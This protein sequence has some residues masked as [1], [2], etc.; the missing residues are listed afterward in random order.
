MGADDGHHTGNVRCRV[1]VS[2]RVQGVFFRDTCR[3][4]ADRLGLCG[5]V[6][7]RRDGTV[8]AV[9]EGDRNDVGELVAWCRE[10]PARAIVTDLQIVDEPVA[11]EGPFRIID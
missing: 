9:I 5:W 2:G 6:R 1:I 10:G 8:E 3:R 11:G 7:N 4:V